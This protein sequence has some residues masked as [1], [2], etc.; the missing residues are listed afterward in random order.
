MPIGFQQQWLR[1]P[2]YKIRKL[3]LS[4]HT[5]TLESVW[6]FTSLRRTYRVEPVCIHLFIYRQTLCPVGSWRRDGLLLG[7]YLDG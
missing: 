2:R 6:K 1:F 7:S 3:A 4:R 5:N